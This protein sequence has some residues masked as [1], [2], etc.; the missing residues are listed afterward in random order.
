MAAPELETRLKKIVA[1]QLV[2]THVELGPDLIGVPA[3]AAQP[4]TTPPPSN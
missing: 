3:S 2:R 4:Q 1:E